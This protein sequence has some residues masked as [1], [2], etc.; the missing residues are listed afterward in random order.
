MSGGS[1]YITRQNG[2][3]EFWPTTSFL[4]IALE[5]LNAGSLTNSELRP[6]S[7]WPLGPTAPN[8]PTGKKEPPPLS[9]P[10]A[11]KRFRETR[12]AVSTQTNAALCS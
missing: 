12:S 10:T 7:Q 1:I 3:V 5:Y 11:V 8:I 9:S 2:P 6:R 4:D